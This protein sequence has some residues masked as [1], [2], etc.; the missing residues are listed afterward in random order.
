MINY[1]HRKSYITVCIRTNY[2]NGVS[3]NFGFER[4][5]YSTENAS[6]KHINDT[7]E[8][9]TRSYFE[10]L[11]KSVKL[12]NGENTLDRVSAD[13]LSIYISGMFQAGIHGKL[14]SVVVG[15]NGVDLY[16][17]CQVI[18]GDIESVYSTERSQ[19]LINDPSGIIKSITRVD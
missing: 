11:A 14:I 15:E 16:L 2:Y 8:G 12:L 19:K 18:D 4:S 5:E 6:Y 1:S 17:S 13:S 7:A 9:W 10:M 3:S